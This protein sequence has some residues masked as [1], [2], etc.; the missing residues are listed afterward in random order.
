[1][2][3]EPQLR[4]FNLHIHN[5]VEPSASVTIES[6]LALPPWAAPRCS[7]LQEKKREKEKEAPDFQPPTQPDPSP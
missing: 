3:Y 5:P 2:V 4:C 1:M 7:C 6:T